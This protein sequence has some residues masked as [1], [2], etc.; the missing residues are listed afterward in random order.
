MPAS[1]TPPH[2]RG[3]PAPGHGQRRRAQRGDR[4][5]GPAVLLLHGFPHT[6][7]LWSDVIGRPRRAIPRDRPGPARTRRERH[8]PRRL[9]RRHPRHRR[10]SAPRR[11][12]RD[13]G[14]GGR[15]R[16][17]HPAGLP[18]RHAPPRPR[19]TARGHGVAAGPAARRRGLPRRRATVVVRLPRR[20]RPRGNRPDRARGA[21]IDWFLDAGTLGRGRARDIRDAFVRAYTGSEALRCAFSYYRALPTSARQIQDAA[22]P[23]G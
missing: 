3:R 8:E 20:T 22:R 1:R 5:G 11:A 16:R 18:A 12:R 14:S 10:R 23:A 21:Y 15:H 9:R 13:L 6:W 2:H 19:P 17:G 7:Q 4:R